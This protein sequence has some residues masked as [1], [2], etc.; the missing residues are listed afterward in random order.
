MVDKQ[1]FLRHSR[2]TIL[3]VTVL[4]VIL[5]SSIY[6]YYRSSSPQSGPRTSITSWPLEL[7]IQLD[8]TDYIERENIS[9]TFSLTNLSNET[10]V[11]TRIRW[12]TSSS[13][14]VQTESYGAT[15]PVERD[16]DHQFHFGLVINS[17]NGTEV[18]RAESSIL[19]AIYRIQLSGSGYIKQTTSLSSD[20]WRMALPKDAYQIRSILYHTGVNGT[21]LPV[22]LETPSIGFAIR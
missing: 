9:I 15:A 13:L 12:P 20:M 6:A 21:A 11:I 22:T 3:L 14:G 10:V 18:L 4:I 19:T 1:S 16:L 8:K 2:R 5:V 7:S 17:S